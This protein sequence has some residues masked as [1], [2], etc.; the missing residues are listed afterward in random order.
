M[1][2]AFV[3]YNTKIKKIKAKN[4]NNTHCFT[5]SMLNKSF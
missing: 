2:C 5:E 3:G 4:K 1:N